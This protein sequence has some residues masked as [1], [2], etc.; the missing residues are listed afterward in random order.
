MDLNH[1]DRRP[2]KPWTPELD[3]RSE[4][5]RSG[6]APAAAALL[7]H[8]ESAG[9]VLARWVE[10]EDEEEMLIPA[11]HGGYE[12]L[13]ADAL[14][15]DLDKIDREQRALLG[16]LRAIHAYD[17]DRKERARLAVERYNK[18]AQERGADA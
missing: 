13:I 16:Y 11:N 5:I 10:N 12:R 6:Q 14:G 17:A 1:P 7:D 15:L 8:L 18:R 2:Q 3:R 4:V 9:I